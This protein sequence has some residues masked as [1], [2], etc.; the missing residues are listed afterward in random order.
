MENEEAT[1]KTEEKTAAPEQKPTNRTTLKVLLVILVVLLVFGGVAGLSMAFHWSGLGGKGELGMMRGGGCRAERGNFGARGMKNSSLSARVSG[2]IT[3]IDGNN[4]TVKTSS[5]DIA[6]V[7]SD[8]TSLR[9]SGEIAKQSDLK[10]DDTISVIG[11]SNS[12]GVL[13][14]TFIT[15]K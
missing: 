5:K 14:A 10:V 1:K 2:K 3:A 9:Q 4:V 13:N 11:A 15:I 7:I 6:V 8:S 12:T